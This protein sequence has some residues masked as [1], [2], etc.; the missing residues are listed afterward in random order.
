[1]TENPLDDVMHRMH[2]NTISTS[3]KNIQSRSGHW[4]KE[5]NL[6]EQLDI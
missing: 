2:H 5:K 1:M 6:D 3:I 4:K